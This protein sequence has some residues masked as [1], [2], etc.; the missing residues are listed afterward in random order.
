MQAVNILEQ[1]A[2]LVL[3][4][5]DLL[6][7]RHGAGHEFIDIKLLLEGL[8]CQACNFIILFLELVVSA[9]HVRCEPYLSCTHVSFHMI[10]RLTYLSS[11]GLV[12]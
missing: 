3:H 11:G 4:L 6:R 5:L 2:Y 9:G 8:L 10:A 1:L 12:T 7:M